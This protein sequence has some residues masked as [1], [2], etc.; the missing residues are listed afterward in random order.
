VERFIE[1]MKENNPQSVATQ[2]K[3]PFPRTTPIKDI[4]N[5][6]EFVANYDF[7]FDENIIQEVTN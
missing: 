5:E 4:A 7:I 1:L 2:T 6:K 3:Y